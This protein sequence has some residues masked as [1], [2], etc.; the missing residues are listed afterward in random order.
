MSMK[1]ISYVSL[2][3]RGFISGK[4]SLPLHHRQLQVKELAKAVVIAIFLGHWCLNKRQ[5]LVNIRLYSYHMEELRVK[6]KF[7]QLQSTDLK[8]LQCAV[9]PLGNVREYL[10]G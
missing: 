3:V 9:P 10:A 6:S 7:I 5:Q 4:F 8:E 1:H 2:H